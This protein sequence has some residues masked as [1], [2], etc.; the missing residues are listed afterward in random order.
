MLVSQALRYPFQG[1]G[2]T[3]R[4]LILTLIQLIP[5]VGQLILIGYGF[6]I[7][8]AFYADQAEL[9]TLQWLSALKNGLRFLLAGLG[10]LSCQSS[11]QLAP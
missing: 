2:C 10:Y 1:K 8:R 11:P 5:V 6:D 4:I 3:H 7:V 9:P